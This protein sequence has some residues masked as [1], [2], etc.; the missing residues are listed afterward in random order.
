MTYKRQAQFLPAL[1]WHWWWVLQELACAATEVEKISHWH[2]SCILRWSHIGTILDRRRWHGERVGYGRR[3]DIM[4]IASTSHNRDTTSTQLAQ[5]RS[6]ITTMSITLEQVHELDHATLLASGNP[7]YNKAI[8]ELE[9]MRWV[10]LPRPFSCACEFTSSHRACHTQL[11][12]ELESGY[13]HVLYFFTDTHRIEFNSSRFPLSSAHIIRSVRI[14]RNGLQLIHRVTGP[15]ILS[16]AHDDDADTT[17]VD[18]GELLDSENKEN[19]NP[20]IIA[21]KKEAQKLWS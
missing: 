2:M 17:L 16:S 4:R 15:F 20:F 9:Q 13:V 12:R 7:C 21:T 18:T 8:N 6:P 14:T 5:Q 11:L 3:G 1:R 10:F 19:V